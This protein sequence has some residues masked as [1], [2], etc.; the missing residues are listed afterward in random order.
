MKEFLTLSYWFNFRPGS[1]LPLIERIFLSFIAFLFIM[2]L[3]FA[4]AK[5]RLAKNIY[6]RLWQSLYSF[7]LT[8]AIIGLCLAFFY[9][10]MVP[11][12]SARFWLIIWFVSMLIWLFL[13]VKQV[14]DLRKKKIMVAKEKEFKRYIP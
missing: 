6:S 12:L 4:L 3:L 7:C 9:Y 5:K 8:N 14:I 10:E 1:F 2:T 11:F 13:I